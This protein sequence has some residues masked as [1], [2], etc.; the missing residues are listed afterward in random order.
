MNGQLIISIEGAVPATWVFYVDISLDNPGTLMDV[1]PDAK[2]R[3]GHTILATTIKNRLAQAVQASVDAG[4]KEIILVGHSQGG[5]IAEILGVSYQLDFPD[6]TVTV[7][8]FNQPQSGNAPWAA[9]VDAV[10]PG[11]FGYA[12]RMNDGIA[13]EPGS[14][15]FGD[16]IHPA[17]EIWLPNGAA[18]DGWVQCP[19]R[20]NPACS[21]GLTDGLGNANSPV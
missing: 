1:V 14:T 4:V 11:Q 13:H 10:L 9:V 6:L 19:G 12:V 5:S 8:A 21:M 3:I 2:I 18:E 17:G 16:Y 15:I 20:E 7:R